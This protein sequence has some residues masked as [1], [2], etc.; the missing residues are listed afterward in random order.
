LPTAR[1]WAAGVCGF[2]LLVAG[3]LLAIPDLYE[4]SFALLI[5]VIGAA[6]SV[7]RQ[8]GRVVTRRRVNP[9]R[10][11]RGSPVEVEVEVENLGRRRSPPLLLC[12]PAGPGHSERTGEI[13]G[14]A[15][16][17]IEKGGH[18]SIRYSVTPG[19][20]GV[21]A[22][23]PG[24]LTF[25]DPFG[26][27][28]SAGVG[29]EAEHVV[30][31][32]AFERLGP[33]SRTGRFFGGDRPK[34]ATLADLFTEFFTMREYQPGDSLRRIHWRSTARMGRPMVTQDEMRRQSK[35]T[36][37]LDDRRELHRRVTPEK[38]SFERA[39]ESAASLVDLFIR[40]GFLVRMGFVTGAQ[41]PSAAPA[42]F[43][44][45]KDHYH[46]LMEALAVAE[47]SGRPPAADPFKSI[48]PGE[49]FRNA[50]ESEHGLLVYVTTSIGDSA[51][52]AWMKKRGGLPGIV[53]RHPLWAFR[54]SLD[55]DRAGSAREAQAMESRGAI[56]VDVAPPVSFAQAWHQRLGR[57][58]ANPQTARAP[59]GAGR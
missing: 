27:A 11:H 30:V 28:R 22:V 34:G 24:S 1:G 56:I 44:S 4:L 48:G 52:P 6:L 40:T 2:A 37:L 32:P 54:K 3:R 8:Q 5:L 36:I 10:S 7:R 31:Y 57:S 15:I 58:A 33:M 39:V 17:S 35:V 47:P 53:V 16:R 42:S 25:T 41:G 18:R 13:L 59:Q 14:F 43:G 29:V 9:Q 23:G 12:E 26:L 50:Q 20:R 55:P 38:D 45:G 51:L 19:R 49:N 46:R 21:H